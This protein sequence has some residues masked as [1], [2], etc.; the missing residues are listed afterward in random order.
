LAGESATE[1][2]NTLKVVGS[3]G[4]DI[5]VSLHIGPVL[6]QDLLAERINLNLPA[7]LHPRSFKAEIETAYA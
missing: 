7:N 5:V 3:H 4:S 2:I 1:D 6:G